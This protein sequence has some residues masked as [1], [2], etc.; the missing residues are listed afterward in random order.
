M[1]RPERADVGVGGG[2][3][4][5]AALPTTSVTLSITFGDGVYVSKAVVWVDTDA[6]CYLAIGTAVDT[7][8]AYL[9][10]TLLVPLE[11]ATPFNTIAVRA[12]ASDMSSLSINILGK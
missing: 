5:R 7:S 11:A 3:S 6:A 2:L 10:D 1:S 4:L 8:S 9:D 12:P